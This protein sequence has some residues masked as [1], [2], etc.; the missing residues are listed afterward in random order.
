MFSNK[1]K[2]FFVYIFVVVVALIHRHFKWK[3]RKKEKSKQRY[4]QRIL[5]QCVYLMLLILLGICMQ[6]VYFSSDIYRVHSALRVS[7]LCVFS[8]KYVVFVYKKYMEMHERAK[9]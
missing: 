6:Y 9:V 1:K 3:C 4:L 2:Y 7:D 8:N 5:I